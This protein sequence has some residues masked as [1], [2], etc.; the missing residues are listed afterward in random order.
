M[1]S[2]T[3]THSLWEYQQL[4]S[5]GCQE[6]AKALAQT[7]V[8]QQSAL[9]LSLCWELIANCQLAGHPT[10]FGDGSKGFG[11]REKGWWEGRVDPE[12]GGQL[13]H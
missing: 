4:H 10:P 11:F 1:F 7:Q 9:E 5:H 13:S 12:G 3:S 8:P 6:L 2:L